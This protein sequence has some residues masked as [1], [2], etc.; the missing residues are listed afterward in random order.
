LTYFINNMRIFCILKNSS[1]NHFCKLLVYLKPH[2][3]CGELVNGVKKQFYIKAKFTH[4]I[5][6][7][8]IEIKRYC[9]KM[10]KRHFHPIFFF[11]CELKKFIFRQ[12]RLLKPSLKI[13]YKGT[14]IFWRKNIFL[15]KYLFIFLILCAKILCVTW[16]LGKNL[17]K[18]PI[19]GLVIV[20]N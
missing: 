14:T 12:L 3:I 11:L 6:T 2:C 1:F 18:C 9:N 13:F 7:H 20:F 15:S 19:Y 4:H 8:N 16:A 17:S 10:I 5:F